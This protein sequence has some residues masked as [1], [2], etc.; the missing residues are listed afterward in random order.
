MHT[1]TQTHETTRTHMMMKSKSLIWLVKRNG[2][3]ILSIFLSCTLLKLGNTTAYAQE[4]QTVHSQATYSITIR[5][6]NLITVFSKIEELTPYTF[7]YSDAIEDRSKLYSFDFVNQTIDQLVK[8]LA[9]KANLQYK[10]KGNQITVKAKLTTN[11]VN[12]ANQELIEVSGKIIDKE[13]QEALIGVSVILEGTQ[14]GTFTDLEGK[15]RL[16]VPLNSF[17]YTN[18]YG[19]LPVTKKATNQHDVDFSLQIDNK[20]LEEIVIVGYGEVQKKDVVGSVGIVD[21]KDLAKAPVNAFD[22]AL[23]GRI[24]G[25]QVSS[26]EDGQPGAG[27][28]IVIRGQGSLTQ[29]TQPLYV[30]DGVP[31]EDFDNSS[32][33]PDDIASITILK[34]AS[35]TAIY[36]ARGANGVIVI[37]TKTGE[38]GKPVYDFKFSSGMDQVH[39]TMDMMTPHQFVQYELERDPTLAATYLSDERGLNYYEN[40]KGVNWQDQLF[41]TGRANAATFS[42][43]GGTS[44]TKYSFSSSYLNNKAIVVNTGYERYQGRIRLDQ[45][46]SEKTSAGINVN[47]SNQ[48]NYGQIAG[49]TASSTNTAINGYLLYSVWGY[50]P[51]TGING[52]EEDLETELVDLDAYEDS[53]V[54]TINPVVNAQNILRENII[55]TWNTSGYL[56]SELARDLTLKVTGSYNTRTGRSNQFYNSKTLRGTPLRAN[57]TDGINGEI[58]TTEVIDWVNENTLSFKRGFNKKHY[59]QAVAGFTISGRSSNT[60]GFKATNLPNESLGIDGLSQGVLRTSTTR[61]NS[62]TLASFLGRVSYR[63]LSNYYLTLT[64]RADGS[65]KFPKANTWGY[66]PSVGV[67]WRLGREDFIKNTNVISDAK[68][69]AS[70]GLTGN[71]RVADFAYLAALNF[72]DLGSYSFNNTPVLGIDWELGNEHLK[73][74]TVKQ[75][76]LGLDVSLFNDRISLTADIYQK[77]TEDMLLHANI[78]S[79]SGYNRVYANVGSLENRGLELTLNTIN[80]KTKDFTWQTN[81]N[82]GFNKNKIRALSDNELS[83]FSHISSFSQRMAEEPMYIAQV[84]GPAALFYG[85]VWEGN[86]QYEDFDKQGESYVLKADRPTNGDPREGIQPGDIKY[87]DLNSDGVIDANDKTIIGSPM[88]KHTGGFSNQFTYKGLSLNILFQWS[89]GGEVL[90]AN[91]IIFEGNPTRVKRLNQYASYANRWTPDNQN[92]EMYRV[93]G[94]GPEVISSRTIEDASYLRLKTISLGYTFPKSITNKLRLTH[95]G[96][97]LAAQNLFTWTKYSGMDPEVSVHNSVLTPGFDF[98]AYPHARR[99]VFGLNLTF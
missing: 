63:Y 19:Y 33:N 66:F 92:N 91:R 26:M 8:Q 34:D 30:I 10:R 62:N 24:A 3:L 69:R 46:L 80:I 99:L 32:L 4:K 54:F 58:S 68:I 36:G 37:E 94:E 7:N 60:N 53:G 97:S 2:Y 16:K 20:S 98:S 86:Y 1:I 81:F 28:N 96:V 79:S 93:N 75:L 71:N 18:Y 55:K 39:K 14:Q 25:V 43:R 29:S 87:K 76:D 51:V 74:E 50:R 31:I 70:Y 67:A 13:T 15:Y 88:P 77:R 73:W 40:L 5:Q 78:P 49:R 56:T 72:D 6:Q 57:N 83:R 23:A 47:Y 17:I 84:G 65:S 64:M 42:V 59:I 22:Q 95:L 11:K 12:D 41:E 85:L 48:L 90:N 82:I 21:M 45:K 89:Y 35:E 44:D 27:M 61:S 9:E 38:V 52:S